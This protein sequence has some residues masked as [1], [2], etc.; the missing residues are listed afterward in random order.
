MIQSINKDKKELFASMPVKQALYAMAIPTIISQLVNL[1]YNIVDAFFIGRT[2][3]SYMVAATTITL[4]LYMMNVA[5]ANLFGIGGGSLVARLMGAN[6]TDEAKNVSSFCVYGTILITLIYSFLVWFHME[7][8]LRFLG[9]SN[10][11]IGYAS[12][13]TFYVIVIGSLP[14][15]LALSLS[16][17]LRN[18]GFASQASYGLSGGGILNVILDPIFMFYIMPK[19]QEVTGAAFATLISNIVSCAYL[20]YFYYKATKTA[21][22][23]MSLPN[24]FKINSKNAKSVFSVGIPSAALPGLFDLANICIG[25]LSAAHNDLVLAGMGIVMKV[26]R[27]P[28]AINIGISQ[29]M[30]P[31]VAYNYSSGNHDRMKNVIN[32]AR[33][34]G[35]KVSALC[36]VYFLIFARPTCGVFMNTSLENA[37]MALTTIALATIFLRIRCLA[38]PVQF[39]NFHTSFCMQAMDEGGKTLLHAIVREIVFYIPFMFVLDKY[40]G[41]KGLAAALPV[42]EAC[43]AVFALWLLHLSIK[44]AIINTKSSIS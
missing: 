32:T 21:Y 26:E 5:L 16:H 34:L 36:I 14:C 44:K 6:K 33:S 13:Y 2:G 11:T 38:A 3:N 4:T 30:L 27:I 35:L 41:E 8:L 22:L 40:F 18:V 39:M 12:S 25:I 17:L 29:G 1:I 24:A 31:I 9:A 42:G 10:E 43:G 15:V 7:P 23:S 37:E 28:N 20:S 19:G